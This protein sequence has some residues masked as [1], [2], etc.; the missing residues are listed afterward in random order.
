[1]FEFVEKTVLEE[2]DSTPNGLP[3]LQIKEIFYQILKA[4]SYLHKNNIIHWDV[5]PENLLISLNGVVKVCD[6]G[7]A[8]GLKH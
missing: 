6:F 2:L 3:P 4:L 7:F 8:R 1:M 5:K